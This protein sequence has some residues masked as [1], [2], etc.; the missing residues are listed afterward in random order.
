MG[1]C[2]IRIDGI[3]GTVVAKEVKAVPGY[4]IDQSTQVQTVTVNPMDT[5]TLTYLEQ[6]SEIAIKRTQW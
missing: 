4:V 6:F 1:K 2:R 5:Q 3:I